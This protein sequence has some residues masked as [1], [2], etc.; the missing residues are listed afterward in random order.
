LAVYLS[1]KAPTKYNG[2]LTKHLS[3]FLRSRLQRE[4]SVEVLTQDFHDW[5]DRERMQLRGVADDTR[6][7]ATRTPHILLVD[8]RNVRSGKGEIRTCLYDV[9][10]KKG[11]TR[12]GSVAI[13]SVNSPNEN[14]ILEPV[15]KYL[16]ELKER[17]LFR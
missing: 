9:N 12:G 15:L 3:A 5:E 10:R 14:A 16:I 4:I 1:E 2:A 6:L 17:G 11:F 8:I 7:K 13:G